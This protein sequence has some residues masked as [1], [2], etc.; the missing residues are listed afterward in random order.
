LN[1]RLGTWLKEHVQK[2]RNTIRFLLPKTDR[3]SF[4]QDRE[5]LILARAVL[6]AKKWGSD[7]REVQKR[8]EKELKDKLKTEF[9]RF[10]LL[11]VWNYA[12]PGKCQFIVE[13]LNA[14]GERILPTIEDQMLRDIF[15]PEDF[16]DYVLDAATNSESVGKVLR[17]L[18]E[19]RPNGKDC[20]PWLG[21]IAMKEQLERVCAQGKIAIDLRGM[22]Y[23]QRQ[24]G[25]D[26]QS[27]LAKIKGQL[28]IGLH[29]DQT[30]LLLP[31]AIP[32]SGGTESSSSTSVIPI[33]PPLSYPEPSSTEGVGTATLTPAPTTPRVSDELASSVF[34]SAPPAKIVKRQAD[35]T[36]ALNLY[37]KVSEEWG[38]GPA[39]EVQNLCLKVG[40]LTGAQL[41]KLLRSLPDG[42]K[43]EIDLE[44]EESE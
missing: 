6:T 15:I 36:S 39:N 21:E 17:E 22:R 8:Y 2:R 5:L 28:G 24:P 32:N 34:S 26:E 38:I 1:E 19:P 13:R 9:D 7:Y 44:Q 43:Y 14:Q 31:Q 25:E 41:Q 11:Q 37:A 3:K 20:I 12:D 18:Q 42:L 27:A 16:A 40:A 29:L 33:S 4:Y 35:A 10:A 23:L 30:K